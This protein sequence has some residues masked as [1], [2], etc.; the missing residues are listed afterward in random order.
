MPPYP[1]ALATVLLATTTVL[2]VA[3]AASA[4]TNK[5]QQTSTLSGPATPL[6]SPA[7]ARPDSGQASRQHMD[8]AHTSNWAVVDYLGGTYF[9]SMP[10]EDAITVVGP[11]TYLEALAAVTDCAGNLIEPDESCDPSSSTCGEE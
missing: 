1:T 7:A 10:D 6:L 5:S 4:D 3:G 2:A 9:T 8:K 11:D